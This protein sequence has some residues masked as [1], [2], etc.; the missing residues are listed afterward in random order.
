MIQSNF[1]SSQALQIPA[2]TMANQEQFRPTHWETPEY[3]F[4]VSSLAKLGCIAVVV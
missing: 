3:A 2:M 1:Q 4:T